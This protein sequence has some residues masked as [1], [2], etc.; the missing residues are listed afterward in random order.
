MRECKNGLRFIKIAS[1]SSMM[2][3]RCGRRDVVN[4]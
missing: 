3:A 2:T 4:R 1:S